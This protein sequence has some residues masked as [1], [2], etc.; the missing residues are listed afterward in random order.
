M[1]SAGVI[2]GRRVS[3]HQ[4]WDALFV[5]LSFT[6]NAVLHTLP[7]NPVVAMPWTRAAASGP[8]ASVTGP[9]T[10]FSKSL[11]GISVERQSVNVL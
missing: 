2:A 1:A 9:S 4:A 5:V 11:A 7:S 10:H 6:Q 3:R 8:Q